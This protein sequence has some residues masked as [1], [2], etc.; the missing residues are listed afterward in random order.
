MDVRHS[1]AIQQ[2]HQRLLANASVNSRFVELAG[3][4][5]VHVVEGGDGPPVLFVHGTGNSALF[6]L[7]MLEHLKDARAVAVDRP[8]CGLSDPGDLPRDRYRAAALASMEAMVDALGMESFSLLGHSMGGLWSTWYALAHPDRVRRLVLLGGTPQLPETRCP[9]PFRLLATPG[10]GELLQSGP[11]NPKKVM[12]FARLVGEG[13]SL[14]HYP[15]LVDLL[16][17]INDDP[18]ASRTLLDETRSIVSPFAMI[19][20][21]GWRPRIHVQRDEMARLSVPTLLVW[22]EHDPVGGHRTAHLLS[23]IIPEASVEMLPAGHAPW[24]G[25]PERAAA[26]VEAYVG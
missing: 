9:L 21:S 4:A 16:V 13:D 2:V 26:L 3:G 8:G 20:R 15:G 23:D 1:D 11:S 22:G 24:L 25:H 7:P 6:F 12:Q 17:A 10:A 18:I 19:S 5:R 14:G